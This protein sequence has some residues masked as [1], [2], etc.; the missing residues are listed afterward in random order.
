MA[1]VNAAFLW[2]GLHGRFAHALSR[3][4]PLTGRKPGRL[5]RWALYKLGMH[6]TAG[7]APSACHT[8]P[9]SE[10]ARTVSAASCGHAQAAMDSLNALRQ[11]RAIS[12]LRIPLAHALAQLMPEAALQLLE[13]S[14]RPPAA[15]LIALLLRNGK[16]VEARERLRALPAAA[17]RQ[18]PELHLLH[19]NACGGMPSKQLQRLNAFLSAHALPPLRLLDSSLPPSTMN[20]GA[21]EPYCQARGPLVTVLMTTFR[22][23]LRAVS[24]IESVLAQSYHDLELI[25]IDDASDDDTPALVAQLASRDARLRLIRLPRNV[26]TFV[27]K[28]IGLAQAKGEFV[29]CH[30]SDDWMHPERLARQ[31]APLLANP[32]LIATTSD[33]V[34]I[35]D[36]GAFYARQVHPFKRINPASPLFRRERILRETGAWDCVRTGA[37]S[38]FLARLA[39]VYGAKAIK[40][41]RQPL[42]LGS[43]RPGSLMTAAVTGYSDAGISWHR[44]AYWEAWSHWHIATL[45]KNQVPRI[46]ASIRDAALNRPFPIQ[47][48]QC[49]AAGHLEACLRDTLK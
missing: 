12:R 4:P 15:L 17:F 20:V 30:D 10:F 36:D 40:K 8:D 41:I 43:H 3:L 24:A 22:S 29:T 45:A 6:Q 5:E 11:R 44:L 7:H 28:R 19:A 23:G 33:W 31:V 38:E 25:V 46:P 13:T 49:I 42:T 39:L 35:Q 37:D 21:A 18:Q 27:A 26:G 9:I 1:M 48:N 47:T 14:Q 32:R 16:A 2:H 34:R